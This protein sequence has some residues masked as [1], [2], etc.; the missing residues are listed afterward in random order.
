M[1]DFFTKK[2]QILG[3]RLGYKLDGK[4]FIY[5]IPFNC[6]IMFNVIFYDNITNKTNTFFCALD[7]DFNPNFHISASLNKDK[8]IKLWMGFFDSDL[9]QWINLDSAINISVGKLTPVSITYGN[10][11]NE[12]RIGDEI[13]QFSGSS[14]KEKITKQSNVFISFGDIKNENSLPNRNTMEI[15]NFSIKGRYDDLSISLNKFYTDKA[16][17]IERIE[18]N[19]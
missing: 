13:D 10:I 3:D 2:I 16:N 1:S 18:K 8:S 7:N 11:K 5:G 6:D 12:I 4:C 9:L 17:I 14:L 19:V 15:T